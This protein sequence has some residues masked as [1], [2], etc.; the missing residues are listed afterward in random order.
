VCEKVLKV[1]ALF[2]NPVGHSLSPLMHNT[3]YREMKINAAYVPFCVHNL[4]DA[5]KGIR[6]MNISGVSVTLPFKSEMLRHVDELDESSSR[7]GAVNT[8]VN[9]EG[10]L[11]GYNT[12]W[13]GFVKDLE[14]FIPIRGKTFGILGAGGAARAIIF[15]IMSAG[16]NPVVLNRTGE[17]GRSLAKEFVCPF[18][19]WQEIGDLKAECLVNTTPVGMAPHKEV[20][21]LDPRLLGKFSNV[22]DIIY[23][24]L[25]TK[26]LKDARS[27][28]CRTKSGLGMFVHQGAEQI[29][30]WTGIEP[31]LASMRRVVRDR[32]EEY[33]RN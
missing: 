28:G 33:E 4:E 9:Q 31:P 12:D 22:L 7:I 8:V 15:G 18:L 26:L 20:S 6:G 14:E 17:K 25:E 23:N 29:R 5:V 19:P 30:L 11:R 10:R 3:A 1:F 2:G 21:L 16:G 13:I 24:P 27:A 32:L